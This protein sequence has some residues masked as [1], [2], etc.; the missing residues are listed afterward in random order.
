MVA[1]EALRTRAACFW[2]IFILFLKFNL[3]DKWVVNG[4]RE[5]LFMFT[6][7][8][9]LKSYEHTNA[10][11]KVRNLILFKNTITHILV[12]V[13]AHLITTSR[14]LFQSAGRNRLSCSA[15]PRMC[16]SSAFSKSS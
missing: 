7:T 3:N 15:S 8:T 2:S 10:S 4:D 13:G 11:K 6:N 16:F 12:V 14:N 1:T 9:Q 5:I